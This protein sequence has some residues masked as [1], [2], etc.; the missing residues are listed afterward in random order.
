MK[1]LV[2]VLIVV[3]AYTNLFAYT[4]DGDVDPAQFFSYEVVNV[5]QIGPQS[6]IL[7][8]KSDNTNPLYAINAVMVKGKQTFII[9]YAY[10][11]KMVLRHFILE[12][13]HY[14]EKLPDIETTKM[15]ER[16]LNKLH[17]ITGV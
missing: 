9:A 6:L 15:L 16:K 14:V 10:Y 7:F 1:K 13:S 4:F 11:D 5:E 12:K 2:L 17:G 3:L 8:L